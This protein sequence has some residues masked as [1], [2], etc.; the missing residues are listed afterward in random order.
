MLNS[1]ENEGVNE[2]YK[3]KKLQRIFSG[4]SLNRRMTKNM[5][6]AGLLAGCRSGD[7]RG[8][9]LI[10]LDGKWSMGMDTI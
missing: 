4:G 9:I 7:P 8:S 3:R 5:R 10:C 6:Q 2:E 1:T